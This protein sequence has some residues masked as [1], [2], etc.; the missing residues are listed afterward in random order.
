MDAAKKKF[1]QQGGVP[2]L[3][4]HTIKDT[5]KLGNRRFS[6]KNKYIKGDIEIGGG[7]LEGLS[8]TIM[9]VKQEAVEVPS[10]A[11]RKHKMVKQLSG[12]FN[13]GDRKKGFNIFAAIDDAIDNE[14]T[15]EAKEKARERAAAKKAAVEAPIPPKIVKKKTK[16]F[17]TAADTSQAISQS[18]SSQQSEEAKTTD[19]DAVSFHAQDTIELKAE[20]KTPTEDPKQVSTSVPA[21]FA[22]SMPHAS[23]NKEP[24]WK[25]RLRER[26]ISPVETKQ[27]DLIGPAPVS[28]SLDN[29]MPGKSDKV[30]APSK[31]PLGPSSAAADEPSTAAGKEEDDDFSVSISSVESDESEK[32]DGDM[33][34]EKE[35]S[36]SALG[37]AGSIAH[38]D[39]QP[40]DTDPEIDVTSPSR[41]LSVS[42]GSNVPVTG[43][44]QDF[45]SQSILLT[46][47]TYKTEQ[48]K[49]TDSF[50]VAKDMP[51]SGTETEL[52][53]PTIIP[54][55]GSPEAQLTKK[56]T[57]P[58]Q[59]DESDSDFS[60]SSSEDAKSPAAP[61]LFHLKVS[62]PTFSLERE[63]AAP[64]PNDNFTPESETD[65]V[66][67]N[68]P[69]KLRSRNT[70]AGSSPSGTAEWLRENIKETEKN[71]QSSQ[72]ASRLQLA[73]L[74]K[75]FEKDKDSMRDMFEEKIVEQR[76]VNQKQDREHQKALDEEKKIVENLRAE[77]KRL[78]ATAEKTPRQ[79]AET[80]QA[81]AALEEA[82]KEIAGHF[83]GLSKFTKKLQADHD[84]LTESSAQCRDEFLPR[85]RLELRER[86]MHID[87]ETKIK[88]LYRDCAIKIAKHVGESRKA[89]LLAET[90]NTIVLETE[91][92]VNPTFD[93]KVLFASDSESSSSGDS[94][95]SRSRSDSDSSDSDS[96]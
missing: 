18:T 41:V 82:N 4:S 24:I 30:D 21:M 6:S 51:S 88:A 92:S 79:I 78:R 57:W 20:S 74:R 29:D 47:V 55:Q 39:E 96:D 91:A 66:K 89:G 67:E 59:G 28:K 33:A 16:S 27:Q 95:E 68:N 80:K 1:S 54:G 49:K 40:K 73:E 50:I 10:G 48:T 9:K 90:I 53:K 61:S 22:S 83:E 11:I 42:N 69:V 8:N 38:K 84:R 2:S 52:A 19:K 64:K 93:P 72:I 37:N 71:L 87:V 44:D 76:R 26:E 31:S 35:A 13:S 7:D 81:N 3:F 25:A 45:P 12:R 65:Y 85:Y 5:Q 60:D 32:G 86:Q 77:N 14:P 17:K 34:I 75:S 70:E 56:T 94:S 23:V 62:E 46:Q 15:D 43:V 36:V 63:T 58:N